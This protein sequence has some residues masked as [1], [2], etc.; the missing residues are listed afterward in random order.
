MADENE[1]MWNNFNLNQKNVHLQHDRQEKNGQVPI[2]QLK[3]KLF[4]SQF[5]AQFI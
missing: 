3:H 2:K 1:T 4:I 5:T